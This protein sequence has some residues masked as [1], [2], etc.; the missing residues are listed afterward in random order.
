MQIKN[1][2]WIELFKCTK[3]SIFKEK[4]D[5]FKNNNAKY[6]IQ[7]EC[8]VCHGNL[9]KNYIC[10]RINRI[11]VW[12]RC[13]CNNI[14]RPEYPRYWW[15]WIKCEWT[16]FK[17]F[18]D[19]MYDSYLKHVE[20]FWEKETTIDRIDNDWNYC[21]ENCRRATMKEQLYNKHNTLKFDWKTLDDISKETSI[22]KRALYRRIKWWTS[23]EDAINMWKPKKFH[24]RNY[25][26]KTPTEI[27]DW[28]WI[29]YKT[30]LSRLSKWMSFEDA[31][32]SINMYHKYES[33]WFKNMTLKDISKLL[34]ISYWALKKRLC[35]WWDLKDIVNKFKINTL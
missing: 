34:T 25:N 18:K 6:L 19:D 4:K 27:I 24:S 21:K 14:N 3:C 22:N 23:I 16:S 12:I 8:K 11:Y 9:N 31:S 35:K 15:R 26:W 30:F 2:N 32:S 5:F 29:K 33:Y 28:T 1:E 7:S 10:Y 13:R 17:G 20:E